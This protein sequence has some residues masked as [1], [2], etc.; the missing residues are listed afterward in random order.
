VLPALTN[1][2][3]VLDSG[4]H[5]VIGGSGRGISSEKVAMAMSNGR[6]IGAELLEMR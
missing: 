4:L 3:S 5:S 6:P 2:L 1:I